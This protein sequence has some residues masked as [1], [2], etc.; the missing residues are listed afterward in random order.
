[1]MV[2][3]LYEVEAEGLYKKACYM[4]EVSACLKL[5]DGGNASA[6][7][8]AGEFYDLGVGGTEDKAKAADFYQKACDGG[9]ARGCAKLGDLY[10]TG[11]LY[12][13]AVEIYQKDCDVGAEFCFYPKDC[14]LNAGSCYSL[15][16]LY[17]EGKGVTK[18]LKKAAESFQ[19]ACDGGDCLGC[20]RLGGMYEIGEGVTKDQDKAD[21]LYYKACKLQ[22]GKDC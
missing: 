15:G 7:M 18:D 4:R 13:K 19:K 9:I 2:G 1:M 21:G 20:L 8:M 22:D 6:C 10:A 5:C 12:K 16:V 11:L 17:Y 14:D 3:D